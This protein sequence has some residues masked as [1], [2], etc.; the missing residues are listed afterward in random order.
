MLGLFRQVSDVSGIS[1]KLKKL[2]L[3]SAQGWSVLLA[4]LEA[5]FNIQYSD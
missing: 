2:N 4:F 3:S 5:F 1:V